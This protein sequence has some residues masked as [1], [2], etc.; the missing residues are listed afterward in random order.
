[1]PT[2]KNSA[3]STQQESLPKIRQ[4]SPFKKVFSFLDK[5]KPNNIRDQLV[6]MIDQSPEGE[7]SLEERNM[8]KNILRLGNPR[9]ADIMVPRSEIE[10]LSLEASLGEVLQLFE[11]SGYSRMPL[12]N[13]SLD[14][15]RGMVHIRD[16]LNYVTKN[17]TQDKK[18]AQFYFSALDLSQ[19]IGSLKLMRKVLFV[20]GSMLATTLLTRMQVTRTQM[21]LVIDEHGGTDGLVSLEDIVELIVGEI[22][23]E[24]D[25]EP[26]LIYKQSDNRWFVDARA[27]FKEVQEALGPDFKIEDVR[28]D[29]DTIGGVIFSLLDRIPAKGEQIDI[30]KGFRVSI[31][32]ADKRRIKKIRIQRLLEP[33]ASPAR[34]NEKT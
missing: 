1:M 7:M 32:E 5:G 28:E 33:I 14:D 27:D 6:Q 18:S 29:I 17:I 16:I 9:I 20:P 15:A 31:V 21:A 23:D 26:S 25:F 10:A 4:K 34:E 2:D 8:L 22:E 11:S 19:P 30:F 3:K 24:H 13:G 12:Y